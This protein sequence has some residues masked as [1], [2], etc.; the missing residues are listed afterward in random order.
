MAHG[1]RSI[2]LL[3]TFGVG[4]HLVARAPVPKRHVRTQV[5]RSNLELGRQYSAESSWVE[6]G[7]QRFGNGLARLKPTR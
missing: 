5:G 6:Q 1:R 7:S 4:R 2:S 3:P